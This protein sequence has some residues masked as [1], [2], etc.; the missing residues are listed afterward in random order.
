MQK[1]T[2]YIT[3]YSK[4]VSRMD[5]EK[6][7]EHE[8]GLRRLPY[9]AF[10]LDE[11][12]KF[13]SRSGV[14][15]SRLVPIRMKSLLDRYL[16]STDRKR[17]AELS[18][19]EEML[20][21]LPP[22][23]SHGAIIQRHPNGYWIAIRDLTVHLLSSI[24][25]R[26]ENTPSFFDVVEKQMQ[27]LYTDGDFLTEDQRILRRN[28]RQLLRCY[29]EIASY[30]HYTVEKFASDEISEVTTPINGLLNCA[31]KLLRPNGFRPSIRSVEQPVYVCGSSDE[32]RYA[33]A[34]MITSAA[35]HLRD[36][37][38]FSIHCSV[39]ERE[40]L[41]SILFEPLLGGELYRT[42]L[43]GRYED[44]LSS[45]YAN[46]FFELLLLR[47]TA[48]ANGWRFSVVN[49]GLSEGFLRM[50][51]ALPITDERPLL[52]N[53]APDSMPLLELLLSFVF[54]SPEEE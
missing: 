25:V 4:E 5:R 41:V 34:T 28:C 12:R 24:Q 17:I 20:I 42:L 31:K 21:D 18:I 48:E 33:V 13:V 47:K 43:S 35:E 11:A 6:T 29:I 50:T 15:A 1:V 32:I 53:E 37:Q 2:Y 16:S 7:E 14:A 44:G 22:L 8:N 3:L 39:L 38:N 49:A 23:G 10:E 52:L 30:L 9:A 19:G 27:S 26:G 51:L 40:Y 45:P 46:L 36:K 54:P